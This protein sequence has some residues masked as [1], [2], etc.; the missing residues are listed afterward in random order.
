[1]HLYDVNIALGNLVQ[2]VAIQAASYE[3][4]Q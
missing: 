3:F 4:E 2:M 1:L